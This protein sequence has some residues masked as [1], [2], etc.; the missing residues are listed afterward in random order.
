[1]R[2]WTPIKMKSDRFV[3]VK[4][5][6][7]GRSFE[8]LKIEIHEHNFCCLK[9]FRLWNSKRVSEYN[10]NENKMN[11]SKG[12]TKEMRLQKREIALKACKNEDKT[13]KKYLGR[14]M[15][16]VVAEQMLGRKLK[17]SEV[18]HHIDGNKTNND[19]SNLMVFLSQKEHARYHMQLKKEQKDGKHDT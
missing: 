17:K 10:K 11:T 16:R 8:K 7:C 9:H 6:Y 2:S 4:C 14:H 12:W 3:T 13:Y 15:H 18:V 19:P 1:M 5:D